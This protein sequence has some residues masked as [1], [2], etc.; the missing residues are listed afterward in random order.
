MMMQA[1]LHSHVPP[2]LE[3]SVSCKF[4]PFGDNLSPSLFFSFF[5]EW[6]VFGT[7]V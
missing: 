1:S 2:F 7:T 3:S 4:L 5:L 6:C